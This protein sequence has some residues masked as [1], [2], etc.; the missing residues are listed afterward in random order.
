MSYGGSRMPREGRWKSKDGGKTQR[1]GERKRSGSGLR[2]RRRRLGGDWEGREVREV[3]GIPQM[4][5]GLEG[6]QPRH[7]EG[8]VLWEREGQEGLLVLAGG[9]VLR[10]EEAEVWVEECCGWYGQR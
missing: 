1:G 2:V 5:G 4:A 6:R 3:V 8:G 10:E 7:R 9:Q